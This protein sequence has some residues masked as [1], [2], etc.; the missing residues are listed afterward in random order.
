MFS[1][2]KI[3]ILALIIFVISFAA[4]CATLLAVGFCWDELIYM[5]FAHKYILWFSSE[6]IFSA[7]TISEYWGWGIVHPPFAKLSMGLTG[8]MYA[9]V[10]DSASAETA[11]VDFILGGRLFPALMFSAMLAVMSAFVAKRFG[12]ASGILSAAALF[13]SPRVFGHAHFAT[14]EMPMAA[15]WFF[16]VVSF[17]KGIE[18]R[19]WAV[20]CGIVFGLALLTKIN[21][22]ILPFVLWPWGLFFYRKKAL[23]NIL[24]MFLFGAVIF[25][26][27][28][29][30]MW[31]D[32][33]N[34]FY[35]YV[36]DKLNRSV[37][38][39]FYLGK[40]YTDPPAPWHYP[41]LL[42]LVT[43]PAG[44]LLGF[45]AFFKRLVRNWKEKD[46][47]I[48]C[49]AN[50]VIIL[51][52]ASLPSVPKYDGVRLFLGAFPFI[53]MMSGVGLGKMWDYARRGK[54][55]V[56]IFIVFIIAQGSGLV[57]NA[58]YYLSYYNIF[59]GGPCGAR[60][61]GFES[62]YWGEACDGRIFNYLNKE[63]P[64]NARVHFALFG[65][66][67]KALYKEVMLR[68]DIA[69]VDNE[70]G[71]YDYCVLNMRQGKF[72]DF[73]LRLLRENQAVFG[74]YTCFGKVPLCLVFKTP[75]REQ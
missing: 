34:H 42:T 71:E 22:V 44:F 20:A 67:Q 37:I 36:A 70:K 56:G 57:L 18:S 48:L 32:T 75:K 61:L 15:M 16:T 74:N 43:V 59:V 52:V 72:A 24:F 12:T 38:E 6:N 49:L 27:L 14:I 69:I 21:A 60:S 33:P 53:A 41:L 23:W 28:W 31:V 9:I 51:G 65:G 39:A 46:V 25:F 45:C 62:T 4:V 13:L 73:H 8:D 17:I 54:V 29:P 3:T 68:I 30:L 5:P 63:A 11:F 10:K 35:R 2:K 1:K 7:E 66:S 58:P 55:L 64:Q 26:A 19:K 47:E 50:V 40:I